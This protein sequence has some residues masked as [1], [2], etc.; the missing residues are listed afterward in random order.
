MKK[1]RKIKH[2][3]LLKIKSGGLKSV[4]SEIKIMTRPKNRHSNKRRSR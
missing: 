4:D 2:F 1:A 3:S